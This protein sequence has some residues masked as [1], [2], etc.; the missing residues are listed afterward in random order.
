MFHSL[1]FDFKKPALL[2]KGVGVKNTY[3]AIASTAALDRHK[4][5]LIPRGVIT[6]QF[7]TNPV[8]LNIH[9]SREYPVGKVTDVR[10]SK[11]SVEFSF[12]FADTEEGQKLEKLYNSGF[13]N[14][15]SVGFIP[16]NYIDLYGMRGDDGNLSITSI[17]VELPNGEKETLDL[18]QYKEVPYGIISKWELLEIS[19]V[20]VP[21]NPE[22]LLV[23]AKDDI[24]RK[25]LDAGHHQVAAKMLDGQLTNHIKQLTDHLNE[26]LESSKDEAPVV[27]SP[28]VPYQEAKVLEKD[29]D[30]D[31]ARASLVRWASEDGSGEKDTIDWT[32]FSQGFG[33]VNL[34]KADQFRSYLFCHHEV[35]DDIFHIVWNGLAEAMADVLSDQSRV[36]A[37]EVYEHLARHYAEFGNAAP[38]WKEYTSEE[39]EII[40][41]GQAVVKES[42]VQEDAITEKETET[43]A[44]DVDAAELKFWMESHFSQVKDQ[45]SELEDTVRLRMSI[46]S[47]M[48]DELQKELVKPKQEEQP[49]EE[50]TD[51]SK[52]FT[53]KLNALSSLF[54]DIRRV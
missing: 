18:T 53:E 24:V 16:K 7:M 15:F 2:K 35:Q 14:A 39:L 37:K 34:E 3:T 13:M 38:E 17:E 23:R 26:L 9:N 11:D 19:P 30:V 22:A 21:A 50:L 44:A 27:L 20:S 41:S 1:L 46:L 6:E 36:D 51:E 33:W 54:E 28:V 43:E 47:K 4:E 52:L 48:F 42:P 12:E 5:I 45:V 31:M 49:K 40:R 10:V 29:W 8:M 32:K 25:Y